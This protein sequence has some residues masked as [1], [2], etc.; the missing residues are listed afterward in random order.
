MILTVIWKKYRYRLPEKQRHYGIRMLMMLMTV[1][2]LVQRL[3][4]KRQYIVIKKT[5]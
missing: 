3:Q 2:C 5:Q 4:V 1:F